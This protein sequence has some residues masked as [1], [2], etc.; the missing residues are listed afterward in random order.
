[1]TPS[2]LPSRQNKFSA[3]GCDRKRLTKFMNR[4]VSFCSV[5]IDIY[6]FVNYII[7]CLKGR[8]DSLPFTLAT[9]HILHSR[10]S[11]LRFHSRSFRDFISDL[12]MVFV[13]SNNNDQ[14]DCSVWISAFLLCQQTETK[15]APPITDDK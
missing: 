8:P 6:Q 15:N 3:F 9:D 10:M 5:L 14:T 13:I 1:M 4:R 12:L 2:C 7:Y 11:T